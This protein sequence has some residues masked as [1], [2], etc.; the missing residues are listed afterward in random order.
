MVTVYFV[1]GDNDTFE[2][3]ESYTQAWEYLKDEQA[4]LIHSTDGDILIPAGFVKYMK[5]HEV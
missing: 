2:L 1:D 3:R 5:Y 4:Y